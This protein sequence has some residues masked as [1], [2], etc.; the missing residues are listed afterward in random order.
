MYSMFS[1]DSQLKVLTIKK[2]E[3]ESEILKTKRE[4]DKIMNLNQ[5]LN[6]LKN[7]LKTQENKL[8]TITNHMKNLK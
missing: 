8:I 5:E 1:N 3:C 2:N 6:T 7:K 4:I